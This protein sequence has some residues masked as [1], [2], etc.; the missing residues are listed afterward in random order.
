MIKDGKTEEEIDEFNEKFPKPRHPVIR[1]HP[2][3]GKKSIYVNIAFTEY[4]ENFSEKES[5]RMLSY[6]RRRMFSYFQRLVFSYFTKV[7]VQ[8]VPAVA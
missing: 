4:I 2:N 3:T 6:L 5:K 1:T 8:L 7:Y